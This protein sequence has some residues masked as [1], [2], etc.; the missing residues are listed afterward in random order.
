MAINFHKK[1][2]V[3]VGGLL[4][5]AS[6]FYLV[7][8]ISQETGSAPEILTVA[9]AQGSFTP[10]EFT[11]KIRQVTIDT[12]IYYSSPELDQILKKSTGKDFKFYDLGQL[13]KDV[14][15]NYSSAGYR[16]E[17]SLPVH[18]IHDGLITIRVKDLDAPEI[19]EPKTIAPAPLYADEEVISPDEV[20]SEDLSPESL[21]YTSLNS[22]S[23]AASMTEI[24]ST[25]S[26]STTVV[27]N[28]T[29]PENSSL[30]EVVERIFILKDRPLSK[31]ET[32]KILRWEA[33]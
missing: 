15:N 20:G 3:L 17:V 33:E 1:K 29:P 9:N 2:I 6:S 30:T 11:N 24:A 14:K 13:M 28:I 27:S 25:T 22:D 26:V 16:V 18:K 12:N 31:Q 8:A 7:N 10:K 32:Q 19:E 23:V 5:F 4:L 21:S